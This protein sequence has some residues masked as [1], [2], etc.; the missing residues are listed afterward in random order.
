[1]YARRTPERDVSAIWQKKVS[2]FAAL[3]D[4]GRQRIAQIMGR[5]MLKNGKLCIKEI[6]LLLLF[7]ENKTLYKGIENVNELIKINAKNTP[8]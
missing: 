2:L 3:S 8:I 6:R 4:K 5:N 7:Y 1:M